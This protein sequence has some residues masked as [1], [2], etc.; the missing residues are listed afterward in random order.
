MYVTPL[1]FG[2]KGDGK[3]DD[4]QAIQEAINYC[5][6]N[7]FTLKFHPGTY[8]IS[9]TIEICKLG[10]GKHQFVIDFNGS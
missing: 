4:T 7:K 2:A 9:D 8:I 1:S 5:S 10:L 3:T 6:I